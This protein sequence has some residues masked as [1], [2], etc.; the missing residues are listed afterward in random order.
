[1]ITLVASTIVILNEND[2]ASA[3]YLIESIFS[4]ELLNLSQSRKNHAVQG[5]SKL[6]R[7]ENMPFFRFVV[8]ALSS[9]P[10]ARVNARPFEADTYAYGALIFEVRFAIHRTWKITSWIVIP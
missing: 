8:P 2:A 4:G 7:A 10:V 5:V 1:M 6:L 9:W 3:V